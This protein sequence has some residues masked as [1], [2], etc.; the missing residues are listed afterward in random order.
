MRHDSHSVAD[1]A[2]PPPKENESLIKEPYLDSLIKANKNALENARLENKKRIDNYRVRSYLRRKFPHAESDI[3]L[4]PPK[5]F[6]AIAKMARNYYLARTAGASLWALTSVGGIFK[7]LAYIGIGWS[8][9]SY[10][11]FF[12][13]VGVTAL[14][15]T[16]LI[17]AIKKT[18]SIA[19]MLAGKLYEYDRW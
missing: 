15:I 14:A 13:G 1:T 18:N 3:S 9:E 2:N 16:S 19:K 17:F 5:E 7:G 8:S 4:I 6:P 11:I 12:G 10:S